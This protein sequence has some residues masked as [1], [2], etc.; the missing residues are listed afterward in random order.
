MAGI[1]RYD[2]RRR[3]MC[4]SQERVASRGKLYAAGVR[5]TEKE[6]DGR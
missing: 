3:Q 5:P 4:G 6:A 2:T 1:N